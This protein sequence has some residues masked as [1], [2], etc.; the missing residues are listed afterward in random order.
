MVI[1]LWANAVH[2]VRKVSAGKPPKGRCGSGKELLSFYRSFRFGWF[3]LLVLAARAGFGVRG[4]IFTWMSEAR[5]E[6]GP[7]VFECH[8]KSFVGW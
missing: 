3:A 4:V 7:N 5:S 1:G 2:C 6:G 8:G